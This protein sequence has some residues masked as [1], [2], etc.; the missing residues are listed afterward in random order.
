MH[1]EIRQF[2]SAHF[3]DNQLTDGDSLTEGSRTLP[4]HKDWCFAPYV[5]FDVME[6]C[7]RTAASQSLYNEAE[8]DAALSVYLALQHRYFQSASSL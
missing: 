6:G 5:F 7:Q 4:F 8:A 3:Y 1:P 2:P